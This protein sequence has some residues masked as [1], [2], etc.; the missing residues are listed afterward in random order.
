MKCKRDHSQRRSPAQGDAKILRVGWLIDGRGGPIKTDQ[1][2]TLDSGRIQSIETFCGPSACQAD[3]IDLTHATILPAL[4]DAHVHLTF[5]GT[6]DGVQRQ[7]QLRQSPEEAENAI[8]FHL[9]SHLDNGI[10]AVRD[11]GDRLG[12]VLKTKAASKSPVH[13]AAACWAWHASGRYGKMIGQAPG[14]GESLRQAVARTPRAMDHIKLIQSGINSLDHFGRETPPQ[15]S[16]AELADLRRY[17]LEKELPVM[18]HANGRHPVE[19]ALAAGCDSIEHGYF[20]GMDN[21]CRMADQQI[22]WVPTAIPMAALTRG[23]VVSPDRTEVARRILEHQLK[24][25]AA[26]HQMGVPIV[27]G[28]DAGSLGADHGTAVRQELALLMQAGLSLPRAVQCATA[29]AALLMGLADRGT[30]QLG[31]RADLIVVAGQPH[32][33]P[34][35]LENIQALCVDGVWWK[36]SHRKKSCSCKSSLKPPEDEIYK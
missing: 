9:Q 36:N 33:L 15:F 30:L 24:Q 21:L 25:I 11:A 23:G 4:M 13:L 22:F 3:I 1:C 10:L 6:L 8:H 34:S 5:S 14:P 18:V 7:A 29:N 28:T 27:L 20:M 26:A 32:S 35:G 16:E 31:L 17:A 2:V 19:I 12:R